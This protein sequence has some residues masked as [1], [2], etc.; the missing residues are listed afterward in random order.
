MYYLDVKK[1]ESP[2]FVLDLPKVI[3]NG[4]RELSAGIVR[5]TKD[6]NVMLMT[7]QRRYACL[8]DVRSRMRPSVYE[9][10]DFCSGPVTGEGAFDCS[11][12]ERPG[13][14]YIYLTPD[15]KQMVV[16]NYVLK[17][18]ILTGESANSVAV[19][20]L[21]KKRN[22]LRKLRYDSSFNLNFSPDQPHS[23]QYLKVGP[24]AGS[25]SRGMGKKGMGKRGFKG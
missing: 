8:L 22:G 21:K 9:C 6:R 5:Y 4:V 14:H 13:A 24:D 15:E 11:T 20:N 19:F 12:G 7:F 3:S 1:E 2:S 10:H 18:G 25:R 23:V 16:V 17:F